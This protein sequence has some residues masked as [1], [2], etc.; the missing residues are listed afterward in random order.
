M[1]H[2]TIHSLKTITLALLTAA[3]YSSTTLAAKPEKE[4]THLTWSKVI[5][6][7][8]S[9]SLAIAGSSKSGDFIS[10]GSD[11]GVYT[12]CNVYLLDHTQPNLGWQ[13]KSTLPYFVV[14]G[15]NYGKGQFVISGFNGAKWINMTSPDGITWSQDGVNWDMKKFIPSYA[16]LANKAA[17]SIFRNNP[18]V[19]IASD[20]CHY[21]LPTGSD[22]WYHRAHKTT[23][24][25]KRFA[26]GIQKLSLG[27]DLF[28]AVGVGSDDYYDYS[29]YHKNLTQEGGFALIGSDAYP[30]IEAEPNN[31]TGH[32][33]YFV[34]IGFDNNTGK[35]LSFLASKNERN[36]F[37]ADV[38]PIGSDNAIFAT[39]AAQDEFL[40]IASDGSLF[41]APA[42]VVSAPSQNH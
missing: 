16:N 20:D 14:A 4:A 34:A 29:V 5:T 31:V 30:S 7:P 18:F 37:G 24:K 9:P 35:T 10:V 28:I 19:S 13:K 8:S 23:R 39:A 42:P 12:P 27:D 32:D 26:N 6:I 15:V 33:D 21:Y 11:E 1:K 17:Y 40:A 41:T 36:V 25:H 3:S 2:P 38:L 22:D